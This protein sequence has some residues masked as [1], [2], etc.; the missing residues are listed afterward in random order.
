[1][2]GRKKPGQ[3][4]RALATR[5][6]YEV[7]Y[8]RPPELSRFKPGQSGNPQGRPKGAKNKRPGLNAERMKGIILDE[9]Y[10]GITVKDGDRPVRIPMAQ[11]VMR[12]IAVNAAKGQVRA[13][14]LF[15]ELLSSTESANKLLHD[16]WLETAITYKIEWEGELRR[17]E[18]MGITELPEPL[19]HPDHV[20]IDFNAGTARIAGPMTKE[21]KVQYDDILRRRDDFADEVRE[22]TEMRKTCDDP[23]MIVRIDADIIFSRRIVEMIDSRLV[24]VQEP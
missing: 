18:K 1:M 15:A 12:S 3:E 20:I 23:K 24:P 8:A 6:G 14:R 2:S 4:G 16:E 7:G 5:P 19:P 9:A 17:R 10:R 21:E 11:A 22:L 13:Q